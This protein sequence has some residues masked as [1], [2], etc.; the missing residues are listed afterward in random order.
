MLCRTNPRNRRWVG[1]HFGKLEHRV[2]I[3]KGGIGDCGGFARGFLGLRVVFLVVRLP[4]LGDGDDGEE[5]AGCSNPGATASDRRRKQDR[6]LLFKLAVWVS[7]VVSVG[8]SSGSM[9]PSS[10]YQ[11]PGIVVREWNLPYGRISR[12]SV[13]AAFP[14]GGPASSV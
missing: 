4:N 1:V 10:F 14:S 3:R 13:H 6:R 5:S 9:A 8:L 11:P 12:P 2:D 7:V